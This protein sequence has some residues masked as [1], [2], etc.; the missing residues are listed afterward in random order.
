M[1]EYDDKGNR[2]F[3]TDDPEGNRWARQAKEKGLPKGTLDFAGFMARPS[4]ER[5]IGQTS[6]K[7]N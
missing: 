2:S 7:T 3:S 6:E 4:E 5:G 1:S